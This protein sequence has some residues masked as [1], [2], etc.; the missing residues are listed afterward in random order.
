MKEGVDALGRVRAQAIV[1]LVLAFLAGAFAGG[2]I[3]RVSL[4]QLGARAFARGFGR[5]GPGG[6]DGRGGRSGDRGPRGGGGRSGLPGIYES[7][8]LSDAQRAK[9]DT[10]VKKRRT[11]VDSLMQ[12][13][14]AVFTAAYDSTNKEIVELLTAEQKV[15]FEAARPR[16]RGFGGPCGAPRWAGTQARQ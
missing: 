10:I 3:E 14:C 6:P 9:V 2:A 13:G 4:R 15:K 5:G 16:A 1:L 11:R 7:L 8:G 12:A